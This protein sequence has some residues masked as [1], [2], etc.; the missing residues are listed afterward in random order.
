MGDVDAAVIVDGK[1]AVD[2]TLAVRV[3]PAAKAADGAGARWGVGYAT[4]LMAHTAGGR[5]GVGA[6]A[7]ATR[8][9]PWD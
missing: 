8:V 5:G 6:A 2:T 9:R 4:A 3:Q 1:E 7:D